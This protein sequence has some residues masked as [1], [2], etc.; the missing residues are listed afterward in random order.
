MHK[1]GP[2]PGNRSGSMMIKV[3]MMINDDLMMIMMIRM[4]RMIIT[5]IIMM[6]TRF[7]QVLTQRRE[8]R[9]DKNH[10]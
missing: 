5:M 9:S 7:A 8:K 4:I 2:E 10:T 3:I 1:R 6:R